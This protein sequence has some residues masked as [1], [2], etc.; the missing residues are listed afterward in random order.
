MKEAVMRKV[1]IG[2][3]VE[4]I[5]GINGMLIDVKST[6]Y[7]CTAFIAT[8]DGRTFYCPISDFKDCKYKE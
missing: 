7:G 1:S 5:H 3:F 6:Y 2:D 4:T 8:A